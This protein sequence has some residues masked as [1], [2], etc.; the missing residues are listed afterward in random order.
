MKASFWKISLFSL[1]L[2]AWALQA[3]ARPPHCDPWFKNPQG[4]EEPTPSP[5]PPVPS[6]GGDQARQLASL[7]DCDDD[8]PTPSPSPS[9]TPSVSPSPTPTGDPGEQT[10]DDPGVT[11]PELFLEGSGI[12]SCSLHTGP[13]ANSLSFLIYGLGFAAPLAFRRWRR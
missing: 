3:H 8:E 2:C 1:V 5:I 13:G 7:W 12:L 9:P 4:Q 11:P 6:V 10:F